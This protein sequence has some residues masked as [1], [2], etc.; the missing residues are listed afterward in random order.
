MRLPSRVQLTT[1]SGLRR[2][3]FITHSRSDTT[4]TLGWI[5]APQYSTDMPSTVPEGVCCRTGTQ[6][7][8]SSSSPMPSAFQGATWS[9]GSRGPWSSSGRASCSPARPPGRLYVEPDDAAPATGVLPARPRPAHRVQD[10]MGQVDPWQH[11][12]GRLRRSARKSGSGMALNAA[13]CTRSAL[14]AADGALATRRSEDG[15]PCPEGGAPHRGRR[16][17]ALGAR[18]GARPPPRGEFYSP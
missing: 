14:A 15:H 18:Y 10:H 9:P 8:S 7:S 17:S 16:P 13:T 5:L 1:W 4:S 2:R 12:R 11:R 6:I 3:I